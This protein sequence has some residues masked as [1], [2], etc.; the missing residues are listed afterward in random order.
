[1]DLMFWPTIIYYQLNNEVS[2]VR[3][4]SRRAWRI[5]QH[6]ECRTYYCM[7]NVV[8]G[9]YI[10]TQ[11]K[12]FLAI[13]SAR[14]HAL[15]VEGRLDKSDLAGYSRDSQSSLASDLALCLD[16]AQ[17]SKAWA[18]LAAKELEGVEIIGESDFGDVLRQRMKDLADET[19]RLCGVNPVQWREARAPL[20]AISEVHHIRQNPMVN[21]DESDV[22][23]RVLDLFEIFAQN[24][25]EE[26]VAQVVNE[27]EVREL[28]V[29]HLM[30][31]TEL[32]AASNSRGKAK[33]KKQPKKT[34]QDQLLFNFG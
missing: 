34:H 26:I 11:M 14:G 3:Q 15:M 33:G 5:G 32:I 20:Q 1:L 4:S 2:T 25:A 12:Q 10:T 27:D 30:T 16:T 22:D 31:F 8:W 28:E 9:D 13:M 7:Y 23:I 21:G 17:L 19:L 24:K 29:F 6:R 18:S